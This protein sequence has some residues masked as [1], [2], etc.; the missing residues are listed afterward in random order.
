VASVLHQTYSPIEIIVVDDGSTLHQEKLRPYMDRIDYLGKQNGGTASALNHGIRMASGQYIAWLSSDDRFYPD[1]IARQV[2]YMQEA[3]IGVHNEVLMRSL[4]VKFSSVKELVRALF[5][6]CPINGCTIMM[7]RSVPERL[8]LFN[9]GLVCTQDYEYWLRIFL[10]HIDFHYI[11]ETLTAYRWHEG[12]GTR[13][14]K[15][16]ADR[17]FA[18]V[19]DQYSPHMQALLQTL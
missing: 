9:E 15:E 8:G 10:A 16:L 1:K 18:W 3:L 17:E 6:F 7:H 4:A 11:N 14:R 12:M 2:Q 19:R 5:T 13:K